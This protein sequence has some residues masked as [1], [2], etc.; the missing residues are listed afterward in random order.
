MA[1]FGYFTKR[2]QQAI[3]QARQAAARE[4]HPFVGTLHLLLGLLSAGGA[5]PD[6]VVE[7]V[8]T[9]ELQAAIHD[10]HTDVQACG[11]LGFV[12]SPHYS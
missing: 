8:Q 3:E 11:Q 9:E 7:R 2:A 5:Y 1:I 6:Q 4:G 12:A 10:L